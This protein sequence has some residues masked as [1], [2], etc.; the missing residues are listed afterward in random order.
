[1]SADHSSL[2]DQ[3]IDI[4]SAGQPGLWPPAPAWWALALLVL[5]VL[6]FL[7]RIVLRRLAMRRRRR[8]W[9]LA[10]DKIIG[11]HDPATNPQQYLAALNRLFRAVAL[12]AFP[13]TACARL[14]GQE[15]VD[16]VAALMPE[17][18]P[19]DCLSALAHGPYEPE[20]VFDTETLNQ[21]ARTWVTLYG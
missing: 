21:A 11:A 10:L 2:L 19:V 1:M 13:G 15:W 9:L 3:L 7:L 12:R 6:A 16:F 14:Q 4:H 17:S 8:A 5:L 18:I 20:P